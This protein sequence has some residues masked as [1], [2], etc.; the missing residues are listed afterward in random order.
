MAIS[1]SAASCAPPRPRKKGEEVLT[2]II[3][4]KTAAFE[5]RE[6]QG[7]KQERLCT[8]DGR[9]NL[10]MGLWRIKPSSS[11]AYGDRIGCLKE[12]FGIAIAPLNANLSFPQT[13]SEKCNGFFWF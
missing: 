7:T 5:L 4:L 13:E 3:P 11:T 2:V 6:V 1:L 12:T 9:G 8:L 10:R